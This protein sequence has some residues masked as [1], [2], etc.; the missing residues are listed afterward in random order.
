MSRFA[1][2][3]PAIAD[4]GKG[5]AKAAVSNRT[6]HDNRQARIVACGHPVAFG[7]NV[8]QIPQRNGGFHD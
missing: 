2:R 5:V 1:T 4:T 7:S 6:C 8:D 3:H